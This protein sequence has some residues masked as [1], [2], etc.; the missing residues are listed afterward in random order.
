M[1][2]KLA[3]LVIRHEGRKFLEL[4][5][6]VVE[7][8]LAASPADGPVALYV[9]IPFCRTLCPF[10]CF[11]RYLFDEDKARKYFADLRKELDL[12]IRRGFRFSEVYF[13]GGTPTILMDELTG[14]IAYLKENFDIRQL[15]LETTT[16]EINRETVDSLKAAGVH[17]LSVGVQSFDDT[18]LKAVGRYF[19][20]SEEI[21]EKL[22]LVQGEFATLNVDLIFNFPG[23]SIETFEADVKTF[24]DMEIDQATF[25]PLMASPHKQDKLS[26]KFNRVDSSQEKLFY[27]VIIKELYD[28]GYK[29][30]T[31]W[32]FSQG[33]RMID[34]YIIDHTDY[35]GIGAGSV[36]LY[37]GTFLV[38][39]F[40]L[41]TYE[42]LIGGGRLPIAGMRELSHREHLRYYLLTRLFGLGID[43]E[44][45]SRR[46]GAD[47][48]R[49]LWSELLIL[50]SFGLVH[51]EE[52]I[53]VT[54]K[55]MYTVSVMMREFFAAL[56]GLREVFIEKQ[57]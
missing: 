4:S 15:S 45:F 28:G 13:G 48:G 9:H 24:K 37:K 3:G 50:K 43:K 46:F 20:A 47:I 52:R 33:E 1:I 29:A 55:G 21:K 30:S 10:C 36:S 22:A 7:P 32:C 19:S 14:F 8:S 54:R 26:K 2:S 11:N 6:A 35:V 25:Y 38:N 12:Y 40:A 16:R 51:E 34:E 39:T 31:P 18:T 17:R 23:Q 49:K 57:I 41:D 27:N 56:N 42:K 44:Q 53:R 5:Q